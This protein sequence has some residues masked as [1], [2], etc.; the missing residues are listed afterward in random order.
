MEWG[1][2]VRK[3]RHYREGGTTEVELSGLNEMP[4]GLKMWRNTEPKMFV[5][6]LFRIGGRCVER[7]I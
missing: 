2:T 5:L 6:S 1:R 7:S 4:I 3:S